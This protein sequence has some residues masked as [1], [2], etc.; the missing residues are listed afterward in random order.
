MNVK[1]AAV[2]LAARLSV[3]VCALPPTMAQELPLPKVLEVGATAACTLQ[4]PFGHGA[5]EWAPV[6]VLW[7]GATDEL[8]AS[9]TRQLALAG[10]VVAVPRFAAGTEADAALFGGMLSAVRSTCRIAQGGMHAVVPGDAGRALRAVLSQRHQFQTVTVWADAVSA[11]LTAVRRLHARRV[12]AVESDEP[13]AIARHLLALHRARELPAAAGEVAQTLDSFHDAAAVGDEERY[14]AILPDDG[15]FLGTDATERWTGAEFRDFALPY[16]ARASAWI[17]VPIERHVTV[18]PGG[19]AAWF[20]EVLDNEGYGECRGT[21][22][23]VQREGRWVLLQY[24]LTV[25]VPN[26]LMGNVVERI[27]SFLDGDQRR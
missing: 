14:F 26:E 3:V 4:E 7:P 20:D 19:Q 23:L 24:N 15:V 13:A 16:F 1:R 9:T 11:D 12:Q 10:F 18:A 25:P 5:D 22:V 17:Y 6:V 8:V 2:R 21:G 27:R